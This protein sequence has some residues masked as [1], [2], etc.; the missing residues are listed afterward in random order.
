MFVQQLAKGKP[1]KTLITTMKQALPVKLSMQKLL[2]PS[3]NTSKQAERLGGQREELKLLEL[4]NKEMENLME[5]K[6][7]KEIEMNLKLDKEIEMMKKHSMEMKKLELKKEQLKLE[8]SKKEMERKKLELAYS[9]ETKKLELKKEQLKLELSKKEMERKE[10]EL[11]YSLEMKLGLELSQQLAKDM[12]QRL[13]KLVQRREPSEKVIQQIKEEV[14]QLKE[15]EQQITK[16]HGL[17]QLEKITQSTDHTEKEQ[18]QK[19]NLGGN[20]PQLIYKVLYSLATILSQQEHGNHQQIISGH[21]NMLSS[22]PKKS[23]C[24]KNSTKIVTTNT[25]QSLEKEMEVKLGLINNNQIYDDANSYQASE[26]QLF[27][28]TST[29]SVMSGA[30]LDDQVTDDLTME[31]DSDEIS[32]D[33]DVHIVRRKKIT[34]PS[35]VYRQQLYAKRTW[36]YE[37]T[38]LNTMNSYLSA[39]AQSSVDADESNSDIDTCPAI[40]RT[41]KQRKCTY[42]IDR[43]PK[44]IYHGYSSSEEDSHW[45]II[46][47]RDLKD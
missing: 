21:K 46:L 39:S 26:F 32:I 12:K 7:D 29:Y 18:V 16:K 5:L 23:K 37:Q 15:I 28:D 19:Q 44:G 31:I 2:M 20:I 41:R 30:S 43:K 36:R 22:M 14:K 45:S 4:S 9:M 35:P 6:L 34:D 33:R 42:T 11:A 38:M 17:L 40:E 1:I 10:L 47:E 3:T 8:L 25:I 27:S 13:Q 24:K